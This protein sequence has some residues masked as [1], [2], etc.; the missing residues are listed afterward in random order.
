MKK[1]LGFS[2]VLLVVVAAGLYLTLNYFLGSIVKSSVNKFGPGI[3]QTKVELHDA[4]LSPFSGEGTL[5]GLEVGNPQGWSPADAFRLGKIHISMEPASVFKDHIVI[6]ELVIE[7]PEFLYET[8]LVASNIGDLLKNIE[9]AV[10][11]NRGEVKT[12]EGKPVKM[13][14]KKLVLKDGKVT[15]GAAGAAL[16]VPL[17]VID[18]ANIGTAEGGIPPAQV[19]MAVMRHVTSNVV[20]AAA[21]AIAQSSAAGG[22]T[23]DAA[24]QVGEALK[25]IFGGRQQPATQPATPPQQPAPPP[26]K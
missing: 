9:Q 2:L 23:L 24:R 4:K 13:E 11:S 7:Q 20:A 22:N 12:K 15:V 19:A 14:V 26:P 25:G 18:M 10:G 17:P 8:R 3:T 16:A 5:S 6:N 1:F 21:G